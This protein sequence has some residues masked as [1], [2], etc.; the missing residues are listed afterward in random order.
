MGL[1]HITRFLSKKVLLPLTAITA[2]GCNATGNREIRKDEIPFHQEYMNWE[3]GA[4]SSKDI[5]K[6]VL[7]TQPASNSQ[8]PALSEDFKKL[9]DKECPTST[10][11]GAAYV[12]LMNQNAAIADLL[13][14]TKLRR[15]VLHDAA[16][17]VDY[18]A[19]EQYGE[20]NVENIETALKSFSLSLSNPNY[21]MRVQLLQKLGNNPEFEKIL[22]YNEENLG[23]LRQV[24]TAISD[25]ETI[26]GNWNSVFDASDSASKITSAL[27]GKDQ[28]AEGKQTLDK[29]LAMKIKDCGF[30]QE[31]EFMDEFEGNPEMTLEQ[32]YNQLLKQIDEEVSSWD[33]ESRHEISNDYAAKLLE[34]VKEA[35]MHPKD[36]NLS[37]EQFQSA[38]RYVLRDIA[39]K[40]VNGERVNRITP[41]DRGFNLF[42]DIV[43]PAL[44]GYSVIAMIANAR[45]AFTQ[46]SYSPEADDEQEEAGLE[47]SLVYGSRIRTGYQTRENFS[48]ST[49]IATRKFWSATISTAAQVGSLYFLLKPSGSSGG[50]SGGGS[51]N[52]PAA[53]GGSDVGDHTGPGGN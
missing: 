53:Q 46:E 17:N 18:E 30:S 36:G 34:I 21:E 16:K 11:E 14:S 39:T 29:I 9:V 5:A 40:D 7:E 4:A 25:L 23:A 33:D 48:G 10:P 2:I 51:D 32:A 49:A 42:K 50:G 47:E 52:H 27:T 28:Y 19:F 41:K 31:S 13:D 35:Y 6:K 20:A 1:E 12:Q 3:Y 24:Y 26:E 43:F 37:K 22:S 45:T 15:V 8:L 44:P 38:I